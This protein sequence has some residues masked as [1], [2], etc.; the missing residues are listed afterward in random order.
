RESGTGLQTRP[1]PD[2]LVLAR[3]AREAAQR[4]R[5]VDHRQLRPRIAPFD[6]RGEILGAAQGL[7]EMAKGERLGM[8]PVQV[9][10]RDDTGAGRPVEGED[11]LLA[12]AVLEIAVI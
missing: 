9:A 3:Q 11:E 8:V 5:G 7:L 6:P 4:Q 2:D 10:T 12:V 1:H